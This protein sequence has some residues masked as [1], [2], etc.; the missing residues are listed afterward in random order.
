MTE[1]WARRCDTCGG[2]MVISDRFLV[3]AGA[4]VPVC[5]SLNGDLIA[6]ACYPCGRHE[7]IPQDA[8]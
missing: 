3:R 1:A 7:F 5:A 6:W 4:L 8:R 2:P